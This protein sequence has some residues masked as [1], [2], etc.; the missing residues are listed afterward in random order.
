MI[1]YNDFLFCLIKKKNPEIYGFIVLKDIHHFCIQLN[2]LISALLS[3]SI[4][5]KI[6]VFPTIFGTCFVILVV[7]SWIHYLYPWYSL[8]NTWNLDKWSLFVQKW[9]FNMLTI[10]TQFPLGL[11]LSMPGFF[12]SSLPVFSKG[13]FW[14]SS[15]RFWFSE[16]LRNKFFVFFFNVHVILIHC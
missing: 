10:R 11:Q 16:I 15:Q 6:P 13:R 8:M 12:S 1:K 14:D 2:S 9:C 3:F 7:L 5:Y 4:P